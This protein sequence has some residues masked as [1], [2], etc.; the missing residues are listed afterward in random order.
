M[1]NVTNTTTT[2]QAGAGQT[3][4]TAFETPT[5]VLMNAPAAA[6]A[7]VSKTDT[8]QGDLEKLLKEYKE[9]TGN[10][11]T[12]GIVRPKTQ[13]PVSNGA[14]HHAQVDISDSEDEEEEL[15]VGGKTK[16][17]PNAPLV[18]ST[19]PSAMNFR[20]AL[21]K[22]EETVL[23]YTQKLLKEGKVA[24]EPKKEEEEVTVKEPKDRPFIKWLFIFIIS[25]GIVGFLTVLSLQVIHYLRDDHVHV[26]HTKLQPEGKQFKVTYSYTT[27]GRP[28]TVS[29]TVPKGPKLDRLMVVMYA[30]MLLMHFLTKYFTPAGFIM[31]A[32]IPINSVG[33]YALSMF[34]PTFI[35]GFLLT[36]GP[37]SF[38]PL[39]VLTTV[40]SILWRI[41][42]GDTNWALAD[43]V[44]YAAGVG[45]YQLWALLELPFFPVS[46]LLEC[47]IVFGIVLGTKIALLSLPS[48]KKIYHWSGETV[49]STYVDLKH[50]L[51]Q[52]ASTFNLGIGP[53]F[54]SAKTPQQNHGGVVHDGVRLRRT[55]QSG[56]AEQP[57]QR[58]VPQKESKS[59]IWPNGVGQ[60]IL[61]TTS[62][63][64][65]F[66]TNL[67][68]PPCY[69]KEVAT[70]GPQFPVKILDYFIQVLDDRGEFVGHAVPFMGAVVILKH[71]VPNKKVGDKILV[72]FRGNEYHLKILKQTLPRQPGQSE[73]LY[74][75][76]PP[77][78]CESVRREK[79]PMPQPIILRSYVN[80]EHCISPGSTITGFKHTANTSGGTS[81]SPI[82]STNGNLV[83]IHWGGIGSVNGYV[84]VQAIIDSLSGGIDQEAKPKYI[85]R[86]GRGKGKGK[87]KKGLG[88]FFTNEEYDDLI[89][90]K[91]MTKQQI[92]DLIDYMKHTSNDYDEDE[93]EAVIQLESGHQIPINSPLEEWFVVTYYH[94]IMNNPDFCV[95]NEPGCKCSDFQE[96]LE[97]E[98]TEVIG[99]GP[100]WQ[101]IAPKNRAAPLLS[102]EGAKRVSFLDLHQETLDQQV[103]AELMDRLDKLRSTDVPI[104]HREEIPFQ[105]TGEMSDKPKLI[106]PQPGPQDTINQGLTNLLQQMETVEQLTPQSYE[107]LKPLVAKFQEQYS[108]LK[109]STGS[110][111]HQSKRSRNQPNQT[112][113]GPT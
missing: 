25:L 47:A 80:M 22:S 63:V 53:L 107:Q 18:L 56:N 54:K 36:M 106:S 38:I 49:T 84:G 95:C 44:L 92:W 4:F 1:A 89:N 21:A 24:E 43:C 104:T 96:R 26:P 97:D 73:V 101:M 55:R 86:V 59:E 99:N 91:G 37:T 65:T 51:G 14:V 108:K 61:N 78:G 88:K 40:T 102:R 94:H 31:C 45:G 90:N 19:P 66:L 111:K 29:T 8:R 72:I 12:A 3:G 41:F 35:A 105:I 20:K 7:A 77:P 100:D 74:W 34:A 81:G 109:A 39:S 16:Y 13:F 9:L 42:K 27:T 11:Y 93:Y 15:F 79:N 112:P 83:G 48:V 17:D 32:L 28:I 50:N 2:T 64:R 6:A 113:D 71:V 82:Y 70:G 5:Q 10:D 23:R 33:I 98:P 76:N 67:S 87:K 62:D 68:S 103:R 30:L 110:K 57:Y 75:C 58:F 69:D 60:P 52:A 85:K 46:K